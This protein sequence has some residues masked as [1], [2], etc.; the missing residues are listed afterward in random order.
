MSVASREALISSASQAAV[1]RPLEYDELHHRRVEAILAHNGEVL[2]SL[3]SYHAAPFIAFIE[4][5]LLAR[6]WE[7]NRAPLLT[8]VRPLGASML[9]TC[10]MSL[11]HKKLFELS[12]LVTMNSSSRTWTRIA[13]DRYLFRFTK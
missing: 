10:R 13:G 4:T 8:R 11:R 12:D 6:S 9:L 1:P 5:F 2:V 3:P 7:R